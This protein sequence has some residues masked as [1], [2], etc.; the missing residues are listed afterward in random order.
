MATKP[1]ANLVNKST[2][3]F[4]EITAVSEST[5]SNASPT[6]KLTVDR[7][8]GIVKGLKIMG[9]IS[10]DSEGTIRRFYEEDALRRAVKAGMFESVAVNFTPHST[11]AMKVGTKDGR[12]VTETLGKVVNV[13]YVD[14]KGIYGDL[15]YLK[16]VQFSETFCEACE[17]MPTVW[18]LSPMFDARFFLKGEVQHVTE[19]AYVKCV[20]L[21]RNPATTQSLSESQDDG[22]KAVCESCSKARSILESSDYDDAG[23]VAKLKEVY[24]MA[25]GETPPV[26]PA[27]DSMNAPA[28][29]DAMK[30]SM[31]ESN[32]P[33]KAT[34][35]DAF[36]EAAIEIKAAKRQGKLK[37]F[38]ESV[39]VELDDATL[40]D[41]AKL[42][43]AAAIRLV[44]KM[45]LAES[46]G[47][48]TPVPVEAVTKAAPAEQPKFDAA[49][50]LNRFR[51]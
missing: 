30:A 13:R 51:S 43:D 9:L 1:I 14:G 48:R 41:L 8:Q 50:L 44:K 21:V 20:D 7:E 18:G 34:E 25:E 38:A 47:V 39:E 40:S 28:P 16:S 19:I 42:D 27:K 26:S 12:P 10:R 4:V 22:E 24:P 49:S 5:L 23:R 35:V 37:A 32:Q 36:A 31:S 17:K 6:N 2:E 33:A 29:K 46:Q 15:L 3:Q 11:A 45:A